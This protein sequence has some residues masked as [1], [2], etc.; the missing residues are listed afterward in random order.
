MR[1]SMLAVAT[2]FLVY[3]L[4]RPQTF[5]A[6]EQAEPARH[7]MIMLDISRSM[8]AQ[9]VLPNRLTVARDKIKKIVSL[10]EADYVA[11][12]VFAGSAYVVCPFTNDY[13]TFMT[14][15][16]DIDEHTLSASSTSYKEAL[17]LLK[18]K[19]EEVQHAAVKLALLVTD[20]EDFS[21]NCAELYEQ[22]QKAPIFVATLGVGTSQGAPI[23]YENGF[24]K[25]STG[26]IV[27]TKRN[28]ACLQ[29]LATHCN[30]VY[31]PADLSREERDIVT[32]ERWIQH[33]ERQQHAM[34]HAVVEQPVE[35]YTYPT[36][37]ALLILLMELFV[38]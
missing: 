16:D 28:D 14:F 18:K 9:D 10:L 29:A 35:W 3:A 2:I 31:V 1:C 22:I 32:I 33:F 21:D 37:A 8:L 24:I 20:G 6:V 4:S 12:M 5:K 25:D 11:L 17:A 34:Q 27:I 38:I 15:L 23:P 19:Y 36:W 13:Q 7:L 26:T 30:G